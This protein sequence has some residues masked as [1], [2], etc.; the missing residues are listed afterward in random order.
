MT[1]KTTLRWRAALSTH[2]FTDAVRGTTLA[3]IQK[4]APQSL[5][6]Q[7]PSVAASFA[8]LTS[9]GAALATKV[10][11]VAANEQQLA[12][13]MTERDSARLVF[14]LELITLKTLTENN[15]KSGADLTG[16]GFSI[17]AAVKASQTPPDPPWGLVV[18]HGR[19]HGKASVS[20]PADGHRYHYAAEATTDPEGTAGTW[21]SLPG[22]GR[23]RKLAG[24]TGTRLW[25][26][27]ATVRFGMQSAWSVPVLVTLP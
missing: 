2:L 3:G 21:S 18:K 17:F 4:V 12:L 14:D 20:V 22:N 27:F 16:M 9:K 13:S 5:L 8:A 1:A 6:I 25:V 24:P 15:A 11:E 10:S 19:A 23:Q 7:I 26:R